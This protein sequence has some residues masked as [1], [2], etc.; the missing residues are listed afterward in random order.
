[1]PFYSQIKISTCTGQTGKHISLSQEYHLPLTPSYM[2]WKSSKSQKILS[3]GTHSPRVP[4]CASPGGPANIYWDIHWP[5]RSRMGLCQTAVISAI[6]L[7]VTGCGSVQ[8]QIRGCSLGFK[9]KSFS[10]C[11]CV[12]W[13]F[14]YH[15]WFHL[16]HGVL[17][18][19]QLLNFNSRTKTW[20][21]TR[22]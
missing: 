2:R 20:K 11:M 12:C 18:F 10:F 9:I 16:H 21:L 7:E 13:T 3:H 17:T 19:S 15:G 14:H 6:L 4:A 5:W 8:R 22:N 1:M